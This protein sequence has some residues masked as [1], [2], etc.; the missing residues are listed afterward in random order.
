MAE[1]LNSETLHWLIRGV[2]TGLVTFEWWDLIYLKIQLDWKLIQVDPIS[3]EFQTPAWDTAQWERLAELNH[4]TCDG[5]YF[6][7]SALPMSCLLYT[8]PSPR[9]RG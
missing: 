5:G 4:K 8:S 7:M 1:L 6:N 2:V 9:D 3:I